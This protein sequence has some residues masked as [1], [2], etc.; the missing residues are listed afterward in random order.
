MVPVLCSPVVMSVP[1]LISKTCLLPMW[2]EFWR[3][4]RQ[5]HD[6]LARSSRSKD[7][8]TPSALL[9]GD[10]TFACWFVFI[11]K[12]DVWLV[13][14]FSPS[15]LE[16]PFET[17]R[18]SYWFL[19]ESTQDWDHD[20][21]PNRRNLRKERFGGLM[22]S[23]DF[24]PSWQETLD[25]GD[26][27]SRSGD[28]G[29][30]GF[31]VLWSWRLRPIGKQ[32]EKVLTPKWSSMRDQPTTYTPQP[33]KPVL[34]T[35]DHMFRHMSPWQVFPISAIPVSNS[36]CFDKGTFVKLLV[37]SFKVVSMHK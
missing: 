26:G 1:W 11:I 16:E 20:Q 29:N 34:P 5:A 7:G 3:E 10:C 15:E 28:R 17:S 35:G 13:S 19:S 9:L 24:G 2:W 32:S 36:F 37:I 27:S 6:E 14:P 4:R 23:G 8:E 18:G 22:V 30:R 21:I 25:H 33:P 12:D 31:F